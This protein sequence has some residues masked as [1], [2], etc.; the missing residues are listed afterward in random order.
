MKALIH[1][2]LPK[3]GS[4]ALQISLYNSRDNL[5]NHGVLYPDL[6]HTQH[7]YIAYHLSTSQDILKRMPI[8]FFK[9]KVGSVEDSIYDDW[10]NGRYKLN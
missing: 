7:G 3:T 5:L 2:G 9:N 1:I 10:S 6:G 4:T 8:E